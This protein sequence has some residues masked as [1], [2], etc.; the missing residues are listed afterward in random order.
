MKAINSAQAAFAASCGA[1]Y[2]TTSI[3]TLIAGRYISPD[4]ALMPKSGFTVTLQPGA[5]SVSGAPDCM[6]R[7]TE[8]GY[9]ASA[10]PAGPDAGRRGFATSQGG[11]VWEDRTGAAPTQPFTPSP[12]VGPIQ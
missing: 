2:F 4:V 8:T 7:P 12:T 1:N 9:Y 10:V 11:V 6:G 5:P 3:A